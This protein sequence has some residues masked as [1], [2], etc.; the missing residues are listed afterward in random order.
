MTAKD[1]LNKVFGEVI[2]RPSL[3]QHFNCGGVAKAGSVL[4]ELSEPLDK[5]NIM[6]SKV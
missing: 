6:G 5:R 3:A 4:G 1:V 2:A